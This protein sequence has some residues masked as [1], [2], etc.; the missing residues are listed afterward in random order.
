MGKIK[1]HLRD[2]RL[3]NNAGMDFPACYT[4]ARFLDCDK[5]RLLTSPRFKE[6]TCKH[7]LNIIRKE[8]ACTSK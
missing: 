2:M 6:V 4:G 7:C 3:F 5:G 8:S 1:I